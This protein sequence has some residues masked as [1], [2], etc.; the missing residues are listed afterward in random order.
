MEVLYRAGR[1]LEEIGAAYCLTR[2]RVRQILRQ[3]GVTRIDGGA[4]IKAFLRVVKEREKLRNKAERK[5][6]W[7]RNLFGC[8]L[9]EYLSLGRWH[10]KNT[11]AGRFFD[12]RRNAK[13][14]DIEWRLT[15]P[16]WWLLWQESGHWEARGRSGY[17]MSRFG[18]SGPYS[19]ENIQIITSQQ[20]GSE[21]RSMDKLLNRFSANGFRNGLCVKGH[22]IANPENVYI[23][24]STGARQCRVC[25]RAAARLRYRKKK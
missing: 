4:R 9:T 20:N 15:L 24:P 19:I 21:S 11:P 2:E 7:A 12:Q 3:R 22:D 1:T 25:R 13:R 8:S 14:R 18:D 5:E 6:R 17:V 10:K 16:Q 23:F